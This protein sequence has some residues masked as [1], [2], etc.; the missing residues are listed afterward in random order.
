MTSVQKI[1]ET[2]V[3]STA[4]RQEALD[5]EQ[6][7]MPYEELE[8]PEQI[9]ISFRK[10][11]LMN[12]ELNNYFLFALI[13]IGGVVFIIEIV[14]YLVFVIKLRHRRFF[15]KE[16]EKVLLRRLWGERKLSRNVWAQL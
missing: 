5:Q 8:A 2:N 11:G 6:Y 4:E 14:Q 16:N 15:A 1:I 3:I 12:G 7:N 13:T 10:I 9:N